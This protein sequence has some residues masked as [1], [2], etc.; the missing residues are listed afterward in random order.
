MIEIPDKK[1]HSSVELGILA[2]G[3]M[4]FNAGRF[5]MMILG[6]KLKRSCSGVPFRDWSEQI[7]EYLWS[8]RLAL[9][10]R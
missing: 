7:A 1:S 3:R 2:A 5:G 10:E 6:A 4:R 8:N 9:R